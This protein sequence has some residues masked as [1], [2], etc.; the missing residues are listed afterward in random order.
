VDDDLDLEA[1]DAERQRRLGL[2][3]PDPGMEDFQS[4][5]DSGGAMSSYRKPARNQQRV[6]LYNGAQGFAGS[7][8][9]GSG[10]VPVGEGTGNVGI[11]CNA[12]VTEAVITSNA[13]P[14]LRHLSTNSFVEEAA[15]AWHSD[16]DTPTDWSAGASHLLLNCLRREGRMP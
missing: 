15:R 3:V 14:R 9:G 12:D 4:R 2:D 7:G 16:V 8:Y 13:S 10:G 6:P 1:D 5:S 11:T